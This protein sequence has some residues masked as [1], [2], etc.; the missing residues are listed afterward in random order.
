MNATCLYFRKLFSGSRELNYGNTLLV[1]RDNGQ[2]WLG[3]VQDIDGP[4]FYVDFDA[5]STSPRWIHSSRLWPHRFLTHEPLPE[6]SS[7]Q[8]ALRRTHADPMVFWSGAIVDDVKTDPFCVVRVNGDKADGIQRQHIIH[9]N[10]CA[11]KLP[12]PEEGGSFF[13]RVTG[14]L[15]RK[16]IITFSSASMLPDVDFI[17]TFLIRTCRLVLGKG[18]NV[19]DASCHFNRFVRVDEMYFACNEHEEVGGSYPVDAGCRMFVRVGLDTVTFICAEMH[20]DNDGYSMLW[21]EACLRKACEDYLKENLTVAPRAVGAIPWGTLQQDAKEMSISDLLHPIVASIMGYLDVDSQ[22]RTSRVCALWRSLF[23]QHV[24]GRHIQLDLCPA[25]EKTPRELSGQYAEWVDLGPK[26]EYFI[27]LKYKLITTLNRVVPARTQMLALT[28]DRN[29]AHAGF[30]ARLTWISNVLAAMGV[31]LPVIMVKNGRES[32]FWGSCFL[33]IDCNFHSGTWE[34]K[35]LAKLMTVCEQLV[36]VNIATDTL[37]T[38]TAYKM[39]TISDLP[40]EKALMRQY[41]SLSNNALCPV[42]IPRLRFRS[43]DTSAEQIRILLAAANDQCP[44]VSQRVYDKVA[45][46]HARWV[47]SL[48]YPGQW[49]GIRVFLQLFNSLRPDD[50]PQRWDTMDLRL[51]DVAALTPITFA[52]LNGLY[53][54]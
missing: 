23:L 44:A 6:G 30:S 35:G 18:G 42:T 24:K 3:Y 32:A 34:C 53:R 13:E 43:V 40:V 19:C 4:S 41:G 46:V 20:G 8:V 31:R 52:A 47:R 48:A 45:A 50:T 27:Y 12:T 7:V 49:N 21:D 22:L 37:V 28:E 2:W 17:A 16:H 29:H 36:L 38:G 9:R 25:C 15:Y 39:L 51:L 54:D 10:Y 1:Q 14:F 26:E 11:E 33:C 5:G